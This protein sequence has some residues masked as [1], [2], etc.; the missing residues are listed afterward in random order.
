MAQ[1]IKDLAAKPEDMN[2][3]PWGPIWW[4]ERVVPE[5]IFESQEACCAP[6]THTLTK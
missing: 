5:I 3:N 6:H 4:K 1:Q 2:P